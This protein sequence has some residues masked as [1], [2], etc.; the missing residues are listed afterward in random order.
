MVPAVE[1]LE[2]GTKK[3]LGTVPRH[4]DQY[5]EIEHQNKPMEEQEQRI[6]IFKM[7]T[8]VGRV[9]PRYNREHQVAGHYRSHPVVKGLLHLRV[10]IVVELQPGVVSITKLRTTTAAEVEMASVGDTGGLALVDER[11]TAR[12]VLIQQQ[13]AT[14]TL[15]RNYTTTTTRTTQLL[16][17]DLPEGSSYNGRSEQRRLLDH[18]D[19]VEAR[20]LASS[21]QEQE[22]SSRITTTATSG[23][24]HVAPL[25]ALLSTSPR[26]PPSD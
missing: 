6:M 14:N 8:T 16:R 11:A 22:A 1:A 13:P 12:S 19:D 21:V 2:V 25:P 24:Q 20:R 26:P 5:V 15:E 3:L 9:E 18:R 17:D 23:R 7:R 10:N 4:Q